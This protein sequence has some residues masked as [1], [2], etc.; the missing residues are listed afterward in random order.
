MPDT[1]NLLVRGQSNAEAFL[2]DGGPT[3]WRGRC[4]T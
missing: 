3:G 1:V 4:T 2:R